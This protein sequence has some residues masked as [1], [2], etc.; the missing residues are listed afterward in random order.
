[1]ISCDSQSI[2]THESGLKYSIIRQ[3]SDTTMARNGDIMFL[4]YR[5]LDDKNKLIEESAV[6]RIR[7]GEPSHEGG[8]VEDGL[9]L[10]HKGDSAM[11][12]INAEQY[13]YDTRQ[14]DI[15]DGIAKDSEVQF[16][17]KLVDVI[18]AEEVR[19]DQEAAQISGERGEDLLLK[20][21][22]ES[23]DIRV[24]PQMSGLYLI[25]IKEGRGSYP[26][27]G[28][29]VEV[30]YVGSFLSGKVFD[31]SYER[32]KPFVFPVGIGQV[33][34]GWDEGISKMRVG[35]AYQLIIPSYL[36]YG[37]KQIGPIPPF[38]TLVFDIELLSVEK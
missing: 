28:K 9:S 26:S 24:E 12:L 35:G 6:F 16:H 7:L 17:V 31:S 30:H 33:I 32:N 1:M 4:R 13:F 8:A 21:Y 10:L 36:A 37:E 20:K 34:L 15:P 19:L 3:S 29:A 38:S 14:M 18:S 27:P 11:F 23:N 5:I 2:K 22:I 25:P